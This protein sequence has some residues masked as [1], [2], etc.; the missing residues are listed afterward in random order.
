MEP[1]L[2]VLQQQALPPE[3]EQLAS[4]YQ[5][6]KPRAD[7][8]VGLTKWMRSYI[9]IGIVGVIICA[10]LA[11]ITFNSPDDSTRQ[12]A[13]LCVFFGVLCIVLIGYYLRFPVLYGAWHVFVCDGGFIFSRGKVAECFRW[14]QIEGVW[15]DLKA[16]SRYGM[17]TGTTHKYTIR[18]NDGVQVQFD[19]RFVEVETLGETIAHEVKERMLPRLIAAFQA[20]QTVHFGP[21]SLNMQGV[22]NGKDRLPWE[23]IRGIS[24]EDGYFKVRKE[25]KIVN[26]AAVEVAKIPNINVLQEL[27]GHITSRPVEDDKKEETTGPDAL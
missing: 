20:G 13:L 25:G 7:Y 14:D 22:S 3:A 9:I 4:T 23:E 5:L 24:T 2:R 19:D 12:L 6:G 1:Q 11:A 26:W 15:E 18:R 21:I 17:R 8:K 10:F 16:Y 27:I